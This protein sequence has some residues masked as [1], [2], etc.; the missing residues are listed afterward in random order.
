MPP[1]HMVT[2]SFLEEEG[3]MQDRMIYSKR[4]KPLLKWVEGHA[5]STCFH[6]VGWP[7]GVVCVKVA[8]KGYKEGS[9]SIAS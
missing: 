5:H 4:S 8:N 1:W 6:P 3:K 7:D 2:D 9:N